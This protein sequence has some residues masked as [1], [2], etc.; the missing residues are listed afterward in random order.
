MRSAGFALFAVSVVVTTGLAQSP[1]VPPTTAVPPPLPAAVAP[2]DQK[3][4]AHLAGWEKAMSDL[5]NA[6]FDLSLKRVDPSAAIFKGERTYGGSV[7]IMKPNY[8]R[9][10]LDYLGDPTKRDFE[11]FICDGMSVFSYNGN[12]KTV[13][14]YKL[15]DPKSNPT[16][17]TDN[18]II[19]FISG[20][21]AKD[22]KSRFEIKIF[23]ESPDYIY[24]DIKPV[25]GKDKQDFQQLRMALYQPKYAQ[26]AYLPA[27]LYMVKANGESEQW[28]LTKPMTN[29][30]NL[31]PR[32]IFAYE[33]VD[34]FTYREAP[35]QKAPAPVR[36]GQPTLPVRRP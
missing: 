18:I 10:R 4:D 23:N 36:P 21:K 12:D 5:K 29:I 25:L 15:P 7:L 11:A 3:L 32:K 17:A 19:D 13:T 2:A 16:G 22:L 8:A 26:F 31:D 9:L 33:K 34:G 6:R 35:D 14:R 28:K 27:Q 30:P 24:L 20:M 1:R